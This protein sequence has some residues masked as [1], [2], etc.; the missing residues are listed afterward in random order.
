[1]F[2]YRFDSF[3]KEINEIEGLDKESFYITLHKEIDDINTDIRLY[4]EKCN[5]FLDKVEDALNKRLSSIFN[6]ILNIHDEDLEIPGD[7]TSIE[8]F[9]IRTLICIDIF[10]VI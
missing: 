4:K 2:E 3:R 8:K 9:F 7:I 1:L 10:K 6:T 5:Q